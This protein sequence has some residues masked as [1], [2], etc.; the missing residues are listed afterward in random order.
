MVDHRVV[1]CL[2]DAT[3]LDFNAQGAF[4]LG[5]LSYKG[6]AN[7]GRPYMS[8]KSIFQPGGGRSGMIRGD[9]ACGKADAVQTQSEPPSQDRKKRPVSPKAAHRP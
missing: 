4:G 2:Q 8:K 9:F 1:L 6:L 3:E 5:P 7:C